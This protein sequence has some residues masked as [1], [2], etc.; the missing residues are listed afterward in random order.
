MNTLEKQ[1]KH[2]VWFCIGLGVASIVMGSLSGCGS[3]GPIGPQ[4]P[5]GAST[6]TSLSGPDTSVQD[7][8]NNYN[9][10]VENS[11]ANGGHELQPG[12]ECTLYNVPNMPATPCL[13]SSSIAGCTQLSTT[14]G[15]ATVQSFVYNG[16]FN[17][18]NESGTGGFNV[19]PSNLQS[20]TSNF[21]LVCT[22]FVV[23]PDY[24]GHTFTVSS[25]D[26]SLLYVNGGLI[27]NNDGEH[28]VNTILG[29]WKPA[30]AQVFS[31]QVSYFQGPG[32]L[33]LTVDMDG[34]LLSATNLYH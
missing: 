12:L 17:Q 28:S 10:Y 2:A 4:G 33:A 19:L 24:E 23:I 31:F 11:G 29:V 1:T 20:Y 26:G 6:T 14:A 13:L 21:E 22:G 3:A 34:T 30:N 9:A 18:P 5:A 32:N 16:E 7:A 15:Y 8:V 27:V 25:D